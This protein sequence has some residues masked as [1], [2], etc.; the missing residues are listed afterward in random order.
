M[1]DDL[2]DARN[3]LV[4]LY[5]LHQVAALLNMPR[6]DTTTNPDE[7]LSSRQQ[8]ALYAGIANWARLSAEAAEQVGESDFPGVTERFVY[9]IEYTDQHS[10]GWHPAPS[11]Q[12]QGVVLADAA[13]TVAQSILPTYITY[14]VEHRD[15]FQLWLVDSL[16][17]RANVWHVETTEMHPHDHCPNCPSSAHTFDRAKV[18]PH[19]VEVRTPVQIQQFLYQLSAGAS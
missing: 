5:R 17:L 8:A 10:R 18:S 19:A 15:D 1:T 9:L 2:T 7:P 13:E 6:L 4:P 3:R 11:K 12:S 14:L 16:S